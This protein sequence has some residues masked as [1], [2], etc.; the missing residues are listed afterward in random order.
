MTDQHFR[1]SDVNGYHDEPTPEEIETDRQA[2]ADMARE[3]RRKIYG[4]ELVKVHDPGT[5]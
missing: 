5:R 1:I 2:Q 4:K 3:L